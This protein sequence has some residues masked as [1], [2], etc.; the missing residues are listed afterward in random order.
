MLTASKHQGVIERHAPFSR[1]S[2]RFAP[3]AYHQAIEFLGVKSR[4][5]AGS[6]HQRKTRGR[7]L[8]AT[9]PSGEAFS[10]YVR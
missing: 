3:H 8:D 6:F 4:D 7:T 1:R 2:R 5:E 9:A 10:G